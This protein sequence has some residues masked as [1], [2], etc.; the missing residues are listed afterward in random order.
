MAGAAR[1]YGGATHDERRSRRRVLLV[2]AALGLLAADGVGCVT[3][4]AVCGQARLNDRYFY[5]N[6]HNVNELLLAML[7]DEIGRAFDALLPA[8]DH[9]PPEPVARARAAIG[10]GLAFL[11]SDRR[12]GRLLV[13]S[14]TTEALRTRRRDLIKM[15]AR[16]M[17]E[18][19]RALL[20]EHDNSPDPG[21]DLAAL[22]LVAGGF[23][24]V[25]LWLRGECAISREY[26]EDFL[27]SMITAR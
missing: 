5:E 4:R 27:V 22:T 14:Q 25:T 1:I 11:E 7:D 12:R 3:V 20:V 8:I 18:Q 13:E 26:L 9:A 19:G 17:A 24:V 2:D 10:A 23:E 16:T 6:F 15:L 21:L